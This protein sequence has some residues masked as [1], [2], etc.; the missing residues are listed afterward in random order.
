MHFWIA[1]LIRGALALVIGSAALV[2]PDM[3][4]TLLLLPFALA[5]SI[6]CLAVY[7]VFDSAIVFVTSF[8]ASS[9]PPQIALRLQGTV[10]VM[11]GVIL[12]AIVFDSVRLQWFLYLIAL[13][14]LCAAIA[15]FMVAKH[16]FTRG[17]CL[18]N[19]A[20]G[21][22]ALIF[23]VA[24]SLVAIFKSTLQPRQVAWLIYGY[25]LAFGLTQC[26]TAA[27]MLYADRKFTAPAQ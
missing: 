25:L 23:T 3:A 1:T 18:W 26:L 6:L 13:Q 21:T 17:T 2:I 7:G 8:M 11:I 14:S 16:A 5:V 27:R 4:T 20:V 12:F 24:C 10:G 15:E 9:R 19:Y 22:V